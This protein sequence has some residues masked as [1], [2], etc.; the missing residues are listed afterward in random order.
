M[1]TTCN[2]HYYLSLMYMVLAELFESKE[3]IARFSAFSCWGTALFKKDY[4]H[5]K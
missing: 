2:L 5:S 1:L 4:D 3:R